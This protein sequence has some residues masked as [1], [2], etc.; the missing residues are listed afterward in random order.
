MIH[1]HTR[2]SQQAIT[3]LAGAAHRRAALE[4]M[5]ALVGTAP[6]LGP[7]LCP[8]AH[9]P[10]EEPSTCVTL[11][12]LPA[13][14]A[15]HSCTTK[16]LGA[17]LAELTW[18]GK[19]LKVSQ[20]LEKSL[21][22]GGLTVLQ[23]LDERREADLKLQ[24]ADPEYLSRAGHNTAHFSLARTP[25]AW[26]DQLLPARR[27]ALATY[28]RR[29]LATGESS[30]ALALYVNFHAAALRGVM[31][32]RAVP[33]QA[34][35]ALEE[36]LLSEAHALHFL[37]DSF[38]SGH[39]VGAWG[40]EAERIGTHDYYCRSGVEALTWEGEAYIAHGDAF[41]KAED[42][43]RAAAAT[44]A[45]LGQL[46][47]VWRGVPVA[48]VGL[49]VP[50][51]AATSAYDICVEEAVPPALDDLAEAEFVQQIVGTWPRPGL[52]TPEHPRR[53][54]DLGLFLGLSVAADFGAGARWLDDGGAP[55]VDLI[56]RVRAGVRV[57]YAMEGTLSRYMDGQLYAEGVA[58]GEAN[59]KGTQLGAGARLHLPYAYFPVLE[60]I[61][62][63][64]FLLTRRPGALS[65]AQLAARGGP[66]GSQRLHL[67][68][69]S[70]TSQFE[71]GRDVTFLYFPGNPAHYELLIPAYKWTYA[72]PYGSN[73][74]SD[75]QFEIG[76]HA[77]FGGE[78]RAVGLTVSVAIENRTYPE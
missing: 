37:Q 66:D 47:D 64:P 18:V 77:R 51:S 23:R 9:L 16:K 69:E 78:S 62:L 28:L 33:A 21:S 32:A 59:H 73:V 58:A 7:R 31:R 20:E 45:S 48:D 46:V 26:E 54:A 34:T 19:V 12:A 38:S 52:R 55:A 40:S 61:V 10:P 65:A 72:R 44:A 63:L 35:T 74:L 3:Q 49:R 53:R 15:D 25:V 24:A 41:L 8:S 39:L 22:K 76:G 1:E 75:L 70:W 68:S 43:R 17:S 4:E 42:R 11:A 50:A 71:L 30:N 14:A 5:W 56:G 67:H 27:G 6:K 2:I 57:G 36:A 60:P 29:A 13:L